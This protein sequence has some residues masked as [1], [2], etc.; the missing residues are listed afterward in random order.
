MLNSHL[1]VSINGPEPGTQKALEVINIAK[2][3]WLAT[4]PRRKLPKKVV[5]VL[6]REKG[7]Q[8]DMPEAGNDL[9]VNDQL[10]CVEEQKEEETERAPEKCSVECE[11]QSS[12]AGAK[13][14]S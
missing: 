13:S 9:N 3:K 1:Q 8:P 4:K 7:V 14:V 6:V 12:V 10:H 2:E 11:H 5:S